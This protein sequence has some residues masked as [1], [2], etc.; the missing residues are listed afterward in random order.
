MGGL[1]EN[2]SAL[3]YLEILQTLQSN[4]VCIDLDV[5]SLKGSKDVGNGNMLRKLFDQFL[6]GF[7][8]EISA[9][10]SVLPL[11]AMLGDGKCVDLFKLFWVV[12]EK[13]G[14]ESVTKCLKWGL[15]AEEIGLGS[16]FGSSLKLCYFKYLDALDRWFRSLRRDSKKERGS[17]K[18]SRNSLEL[19][20]VGL[21][22]QLNDFINNISDQHRRSSEATYIVQCDN[23][24]SSSGDMDTNSEVM[25]EMELGSVEKKCVVDDDE[26]GV[27]VEKSVVKEKGS[28]RKR[29][30]E[31]FSGMLIWLTELAKNPS[32]AAIGK[33]AE[34]YKKKKHGIRE[35]QHLVLLSRN[36]M[37]QCPNKYW[38]E[39]KGSPLSQKKQK[40]HPSMYEDQVIADHLSRERQ[41]HSS[42]FQ[43]PT[44]GKV[45]PHPDSSDFDLSE[46]LPSG[47]R[48]NQC[49]NPYDD[50]E[51]RK[52]VSIGSQSQAELPEWTGIAAYESDPKW[53]GTLNWPQ[54]RPEQYSL[55]GIGKGRPKSCQCRV[56]GA[57]KCIRFH[58][59]ENKL[60]LRSE[61]GNV[62]YTWR[63]HL[64]GEEV[65]L[66]WSKEEEEK[67]KSTVRLNPRSLNKY[68]WKQLCRCFRTKKREILVSYYFNV[69]VLRRRIYQNRVTPS[70]VDSDDDE[71][72]FGSLSDGFGLEA[73]TVPGLRPVVCVQNSQCFDLD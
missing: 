58:I 52:R 15:V 23:E 42:R 21:K 37:F 3:D 13:G 32:D 63:F 14:Y 9:S 73:V 64:M 65:S 22:T 25:G 2:G 7:L 48:K 41:N 70:N 44:N 50:G 17:G 55:L 11:P 39:E 38:D 51:V 31:D 46:S 6:S 59:A 16:G 56:R 1:L 40:M 18:C 33:L 28:S 5:N 49:L 61:L 71:S 57:V 53:L 62:F 45:D 27:I 29:K 4:G 8:K 20:P 66:S 35:F 67:F 60:R 10:Q 26:N 34:A 69:F 68:F 24:A 43:T 36:A 72:E 30:R 19:L 47:V 12:R 54:R